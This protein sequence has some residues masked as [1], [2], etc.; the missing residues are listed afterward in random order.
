[1][2]YQ[3]DN[4]VFDRTAAAGVLPL[5]HPTVAKYKTLN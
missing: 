3:E 1:M 4:T 5:V 2:P